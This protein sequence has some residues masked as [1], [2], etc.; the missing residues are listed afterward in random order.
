MGNLL[1]YDWVRDA[2]TGK[3]IVNPVT[4]YPTKSSTLTN[5][6]RVT[7][8][9]IIGITSTV[10]YKA[11]S[12]TATAD[13]RS[14]YVIYNQIGKTLDHSGVGLTTAVAGRQRF[15]FPNSVYADAS[16]KY[17][18]NTNI[19]V[20]DGNFNFWPSIYNSIDGNYIVSAAAW[21]LR[22]ATLGYTIPAQWLRTRAKF[23][24]GANISISGRNLLMYRP[25]TNKWTDPEYSETTGNAVGYT[26]YN[27]APPTRIYTG[28]ISVTF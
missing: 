4:G 7:P 1:G 12:F 6:G 20:Q 15:V 13:Y 3:V 24:K 21:K 25:S 22:E 28:T 23:I 2:S 5:F 26:T 18:D 9:D 10:S 19:E 16:G 8:R 11:F 14:G 17:V 27:Q